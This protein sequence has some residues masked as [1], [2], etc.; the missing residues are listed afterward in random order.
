MGHQNHGRQGAERRIVIL[1]PNEG[2]KT[3]IVE[4]ESA[5]DRHLGLTYLERMSTLWDR[6]QNV[7]QQS[8]HATKKRT[9][10]CGAFRLIASAHNDQA[11]QVISRPS[12]KCTRKEERKNATEQ[13]KGRDNA[14]A[15][16][17]RNE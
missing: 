1:E 6:Q 15:L 7:V 11:D 12:N 4:T 14:A 13:T 10:Y 17:R 3:Q 5:M 8:Q 9:L 2:H 16:R